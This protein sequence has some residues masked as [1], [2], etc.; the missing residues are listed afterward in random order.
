M[1]KILGYDKHGREIFS[2]SRVRE[3]MGMQEFSIVVG[4]LANGFL[5]LLGDGRTGK[6]SHAAAGWKYLEVV[7]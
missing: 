6:W 4:V 1:K 5:K 7:E 2:G 3:D